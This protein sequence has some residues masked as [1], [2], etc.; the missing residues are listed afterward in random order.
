LSRALVTGASGFAGRHLAGLLRERSNDVLA[1]PRAELDLLDLDALRSVV[2]EF[3]PRR[4]FHL[5]AF[6]SAVR[7]WDAPLEVLRQNIEGTANVLEA[8]RLEKSDARV[9]LVGSGQ[10]YGKPDRLPITEDAPLHPQ[11]PYAVSKA[12]ADLLGGQYAEAHGL[13]IVRT[14]SFNHAGPGQS[15]EYVIGTLTRQVAEAE[16]SGADQLTLRT[17]SA[18]VA[19]DFTDVRDV[20]RAYVAAVEAAPDAYNVCS[21]RSVTVAELIALIEELTELE[22]HHEVDPA[23]VRAHEVKEVHGSAD[24]LRAATGWAP[25]IPLERTVAD[26]LEAWR[27]ELKPARQAS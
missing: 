12:A 23:R 1:P 19:R 13:R 2:D 9:L 10:I 21:G 17:G 18:E 27:R 8:V 4:I 14:R 26:A 20:V 5:A 11:N 22:V 16:A 3:R 7:S 25:E 6:A 15:A 24:R